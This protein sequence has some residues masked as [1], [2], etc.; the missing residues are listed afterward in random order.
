MTGSTPTYEYEGYIQYIEG[1]TFEERIEFIKK[2]SR[3]WKKEN[4]LSST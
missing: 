2:K 4:K 1:V 3:K